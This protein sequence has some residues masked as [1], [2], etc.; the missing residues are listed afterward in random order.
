MLVITVLQI[1]DLLRLNNMLFCL[2][3]D[4]TAQYDAVRAYLKELDISSAVWIGLIR[5][6]PDG[7]FTWTY[8]ARF[9]PCLLSISQLEMITFARTFVVK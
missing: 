6:N 2:V 9:L 4:T 8:V 3:V 7:D 5:S 1:N